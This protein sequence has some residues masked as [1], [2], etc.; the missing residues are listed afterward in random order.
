MAERRRPQSA[1]QSPNYSKPAPPLPATV[2]PCAGDREGQALFLL[3]GLYEKAAIYATRLRHESHPGAASRTLPSQTYGVARRPPGHSG[4]HR[5]AP[6]GNG[7]GPARHHVSATSGVA[8]SHVASRSCS[9][10]SSHGRACDPQQPVAA[11]G[12]GSPDS[13]AGREPPRHRSPPRSPSRRHRNPPSRVRQRRPWYDRNLAVLG[14]VW[15]PIMPTPAWE[16][17]Q[18]MQSLLRAD[19]GYDRSVL[20]FV[21][22][23]PLLQDTCRPAGSGAAAVRRARPASA[24]PSPARSPPIPARPASAQQ[25][26]LD[27]SSY[28][29]DGGEAVEEE[30]GP[31][32]SEQPAPARPVRPSS[33]RPGPKPSISKPIESLEA[34]SD[35]E[36][37][38]DSGSMA[39]QA[40]QVEAIGLVQAAV[41]GAMFTD[42]DSIFNE[43]H[44]AREAA[45]TTLIQTAVRNAFLAED[46]VKEE[47]EAVSV[48]QDAMAEMEAERAAEAASVIQG[49]MAEMEAER[50]AEAAS[51]IQGA[52]AEM[53][54]EREAEERFPDASRTDQESTQAKRFVKIVRVPQGYRVKILSTQA[55]VDGLMRVRDQ[56]MYC[57]QANVVERNDKPAWKVNIRRSDSGWQVRILNVASSN[58]IRGAAAAEIVEQE[59]KERDALVRRA[60]KE[61]TGLS[62]QAARAPMLQNEAEATARTSGRENERRDWKLCISKGVLE[63]E[64]AIV[65]DHTEL[66]KGDAVDDADE[67]SI[68]QAAVRSTLKDE[69]EHGRTDDALQEAE[70]ASIVQAAVRSTLDQEEHLRENDDSLQE[71]EAA[72]I[73]QAAVRSTLDQEE[74]LRENDDSLQEAEAASI[75]QAA[76][77]S[78]LDERSELGR[79]DDTLQEA[80]AASIA[81]A[82]VRILGEGA[83]GTTAEQGFMLQINPFDRSTCCKIVFATERVSRSLQRELPATGHSY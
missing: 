49:A 22:R 20:P 42:C 27:M 59:Y 7:T 13:V 44:Q 64:V 15:A 71:A 10:G 12:P 29:L 48:I 52:M 24:R 58:A 61:E 17:Q 6:S 36:D 62:V 5:T 8:V 75:V 28:L 41:R 37:R 56:D 57:E 18:Q 63:W 72:S 2:M 81:Q 39:E 46:T 21:I 4:M 26:P 66:N 73:V 25:R 11:W 19:I 82:A 77:R 76:V 1:G 9:A 78:T 32:P 74:H 65:C 14:D 53:E 31:A 54:V 80:E 69:Q 79:T 43:T 33:A 68:M 70:A 40:K 67:A 34:L 60:S 30:N 55:E 38:N 50:E 35:D 16:R 23:E 45:A 3:H 51:V 83:Q 47:A